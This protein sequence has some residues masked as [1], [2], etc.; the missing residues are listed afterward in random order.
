ML[1]TL[2]ISIFLSHQLIDAEKTCKTRSVAMPLLFFIPFLVCLES[3][4]FGRGDAE[5]FGEETVVV[6]PVGKTRL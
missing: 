1:P 2:T 3:L 6:L 5:S 4:V